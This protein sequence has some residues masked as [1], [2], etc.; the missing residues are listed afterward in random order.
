MSRLIEGA[1]LVVFLTFAGLMLYYVV[2]FL[3][4]VVGTL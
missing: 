3:L 1:G 2:G 4:V